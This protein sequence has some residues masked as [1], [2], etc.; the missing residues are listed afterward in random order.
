MISFTVRGKAEPA[1]SKRA[2]VRGG[3][4]NVVDANPRARG[5]KTQVSDAAALAAS[6]GDWLYAETGGLVLDVI[7]YRP[8]PKAHFTTKGA[9]TARG[10]REPYPL[11]APDRGKILR[12]IEDALSGV[13]YRDDAQIV[14]GRVAKRYGLL[15]MTVVILSRAG[16]PDDQRERFQALTQLAIRESAIEKG[17]AQ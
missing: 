4:A 3:R 14:D 1:G 7:E 9:L 11:A 17:G 8:R 15:P 12:G 5:W 2:F 6:V 10:A 16:D 13:L